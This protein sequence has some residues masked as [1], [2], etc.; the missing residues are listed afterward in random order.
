MTHGIETSDVQ[1]FRFAPGQPAWHQFGRALPRLGM[2]ATEALEDAGLAFPTA[3]V[4]AFA[5][6]PGAPER[7][8]LEGYT[9]AGHARRIE[10]PGTYAH[11][12][13]D[14]GQVYG[15]VADRYDPVENRDLATFAD[16]LIED[17]P[18]L[19][20]SAVYSLFETST[21]CI[22]LEG[23]DSEI[24]P[25]RGT[26]RPADPVKVYT[27][28]ANSHGGTGNFRAIRSA[29][30]AICHNTQRAADAENRKSRR[31]AARLKH[32]KRADGSADMSSKLKIAR[33]IMANG[34]ALQKRYDEAV[35]ALA[36]CEWGVLQTREW[37][38]RVY[39]E[40]FGEAPV[41]GAEVSAETVARWHE[42]RLAVLARWEA[43]IE[44]PRQ[45]N[46]RGSAWGALNAVTQWHQHE[47]GRMGS[48]PL[49]RFAQSL[50]GKSAE[51]SGIAFRSILQVSGV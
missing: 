48:E 27:N 28:L 46:V 7:W 1:H 2:T 20:V 38:E 23:P 33:T 6:I 3:K 26:W 50:F 19:T 25:N 40:T 47:R 14:T 36:R 9:P 29:I 18:T 42:K 30:R 44:D 10:L 22:T 16:L 15:I 17:D 31:A 37:F 35:S 8:D 39:V 5:E 21:V 13:P 32:T 41:A 24:D 43:N 51:D 11:V 12:R 45:A 4:P 34:A 49:D